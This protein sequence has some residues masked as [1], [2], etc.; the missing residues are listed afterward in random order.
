MDIDSGDAAIAGDLSQ[1]LHHEVLDATAQ[2]T[3]TQYME[4]KRCSICK[5]PFPSDA[6]PTLDKA[7]AEHVKTNHRPGQ[8]TEDINQAAAQIVGETTAD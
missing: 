3:T 6:Q 4:A 7:F 8:T 2:N 1:S 5:M